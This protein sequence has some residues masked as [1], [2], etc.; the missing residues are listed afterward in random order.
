MQSPRHKRAFRYALLLSQENLALD[1]EEDN[2]MNPLTQA[3]EPMSEDH[4]RTKT[5]IAAIIRQA[6]DDIKEKPPGKR[7]KSQRSLDEWEKDKDSAVTFLVSESAR[8]YFRFL[9]IDRTR[10]L[11]AIGLEFAMI[12]HDKDRVA[13]EIEN[14]MAE[15]LEQH[16]AGEVDFD[17]DQTI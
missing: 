12:A 3:S 6:V 9:H 8:T 13:Y 14:A 10:A 7:S 1:Q 16:P 17:A 15:Y 4:Y 5:L 2:E 11:E